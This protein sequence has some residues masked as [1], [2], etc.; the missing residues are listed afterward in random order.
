VGEVEPVLLE[1]KDDDALADLLMAAGIA[2]RVKFDHTRG[3]GRGQPGKWLIWNGVRWQPDDVERIYFVMR[4]YTDKLWRATADGKAGEDDRKRIQ[5]LY[6]QAKKHSVM[7]SLRSRPEI[8]TTSDQFDRLPYLM[9]FENGVVDLRDGSFESNPSPDLNISKST[10]YMWDPEAEAPIFE[11][12][13]YDIMGNDVEMVSYLMTLLGYSMFG[14]QTEQ[15]FWLWVGRGQNGKGVLARTMLKALGDYAISPDAA[16]YMKTRFGAARAD[17]ARPELIALLARRF[18]YMSE[19]PGGHFNEEML[20]A[21]T[22]DDPILARGLYSSP[23]QFPP[24]HK[25]IFLTNAPP[26]T[27]DVGVSMRRRARVIKFEQDYT[28]NPDLML[29]EKLKAELPG[30]L[31]RLVKF[32]GVWWNAGNPQLDEPEKVTVWSEEYIEQN[33]PLS[34]FIEDMCVESIRATSSSTLLWDAYRDWEAR[35]GDDGSDPM[36]RK[37][38]GTLLGARYKRDRQSAGVVYEGIRVKSAAELAT[39]GS[40]GD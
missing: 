19:P 18:T 31:Q 11:A 37:R 1:T 33:D 17:A 26:S 35:S 14:M 20:K 5:P 12:F 39:K 7:E 8:G 28:Q 9:G 2:K 27:D 24:T 32:A 3:T 38:F 23:V 22:G 10:G 15:K 4:E 21:H 29:E 40:D 36:S 34:S 30:I 16:L 6:N 13:M 25:I